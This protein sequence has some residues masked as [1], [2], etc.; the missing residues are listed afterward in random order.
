MP[1][2][3][4]KKAT[5]I[6]HDAKLKYTFWQDDGWHLGFL[7]DY[8][9]YWTQGT[10]KKDL[11]DHLKGLLIDLESDWFMNLETRRTQPVRHNEIY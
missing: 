5:L 1:P 6:C 8:P 3:K 9:D 4:C 7:N 11:V 10:S 2:S